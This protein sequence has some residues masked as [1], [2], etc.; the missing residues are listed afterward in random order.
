[1]ARPDQ[2][3]FE[4]LAGE[5]SAII[6]ARRTALANIARHHL[7][8]IRR[9]IRARHEPAS[10]ATMATPWSLCRRPWT[11][12][13]FTANGRAL[14]CCIAPFSQRGY[15]N[16]TLG[17]ATQQ[18]LRE[19]WN[20][21]AYQSF[22]EALQSRPAADGLRELRPALEPVTGEPTGEDASHGRVAVV[23]PALNEESSI[24]AVVR[25]LPGAR[26]S[27]RSSSS[28]AAS[29][30]GRRRARAE[31]GAA[32]HRRAAA[33]L[34]PR[35]RCRASQAAGIARHR[36]LHGR[37]RRRRSRRSSPALVG[38]RFVRGEVRFRHGLA[39]ARRARAG[40]HGLAADRGRPDRRG[41]SCAASTACAS[42]TC[43]PS[44]RSGATL[45]RPR[46]ARD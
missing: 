20:G 44:A 16:Y 43:R 27:T 26:S 6:S 40:Q 5:R 14:P 9:G 31:A 34:W 25:E 22:R 4:Q 1:M 21:A 37:R 15:E 38:R 3:L 19:I 2:A 30:T 18:T 7:Q 23:I 8:R 39:R 36:R 13:Y 12:M 35:L 42:P 32:C 41:C 10:G 33:G 11:V 46:H 28:T 24:G 45:W 29:R 17:D